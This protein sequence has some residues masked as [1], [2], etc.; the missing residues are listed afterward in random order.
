[1]KLAG[2]ERRAAQP[3]AFVAEHEGHGTVGKS[4]GDCTQGRRGRVAVSSRPRR[5]RVP[6]VHRAR[7]AIPAG[8][9]TARPAPHPSMF[10][11]PSGTAG[12]SW[13]GRAGRRRR[14]TRRRSERC[15]PR[16]PAFAIRSSTRTM[17]APATMSCQGRGRGYSPMAR[18]PRWM[19]KPAT[20]SITAWVRRRQ[21]RSGREAMRSV[22]P[23][24]AA[25]VSITDPVTNVLSVMS[26]RT[27]RRPSATK[28]LR[29]RT[30]SASGTLR[31]SSRRESRG[32][33]I[34]RKCKV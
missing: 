12:R 22:I 9:R 5:S 14:R 10:E 33:S 30:S 11:W 4:T 16:C 26:R 17:R 6:A 27:T 3:V 28:M 29:R 2:R 24:R 32:S 34:S 21:A 13:P 1:M 8:A 23:S 19:W 20:R 18:H 15:R 31:K 25:S 7:S